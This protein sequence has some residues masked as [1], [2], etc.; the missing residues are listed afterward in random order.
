MNLVPVN[1]DAI[2]IGQP[3][4]CALRAENGVLLAS[5]GFMVTN[6]QELEVMVGRRNQI[7]IDADQSD[8]FRRGYI[9]RINKLVMADSSLG[10]IAEVQISPY[11]GKKGPA[12][13]VSDEPDWL[14]MQSQAHAMLRDTSTDTCLPRL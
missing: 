3:L 4:P 13:E 11:D 1:I 6:R 10:Q 5:Q 14:D 8:N 7:Y 12:A 2:L 9:N